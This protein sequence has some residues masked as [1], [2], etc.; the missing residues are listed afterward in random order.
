MIGFETTNLPIAGLPGGKSGI[1][2]CSGG[3]ACS[4]EGTLFILGL[5]LATLGGAA[6]FFFFSDDD[7]PTPT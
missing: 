2:R 1:C 3:V 7:F 6:D 4:L 5:W